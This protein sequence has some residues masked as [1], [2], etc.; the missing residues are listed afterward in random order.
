MATA[1]PAGGASTAAGGLA[2]PGPTVSGPIITPDEGKIGLL[3]Q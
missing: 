2:A 1:M 3:L